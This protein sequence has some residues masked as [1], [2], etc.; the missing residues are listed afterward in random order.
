MKLISQLGLTLLLTGSAVEAFSPQ[1][2]SNVAPQQ[3]ELTSRREL[4]QKTVTSVAGVA[5]ALA[6]S[7]LAP[8]PALASGGA[9]AG[10]YTTIP[11]AK[12]RYYGRVQQSVHEF[13]LLGPEIVQAD[14]SQPM[15]QHFFDPKGLVVVAAKRKDVNGQCTKKNGDCKG[16]EV[17]D[18]IY[19]D[20]KTSMYL[21][22]NAFRLNQTKAPDNLP[23]VR[24][25]KKFFKE[26]DLVEKAATKKRK[27][28]RDSVV[29]FAAA[30]EALDAFLDLVELPPTDSNWYEQE[31][32]RAVGSSARIT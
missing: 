28:D 15:I 14:F 20:M 9:T 25:A 2:Q 29:H 6:V 11:I 5:G 8:A 12:R 32:D 27:N 26:M 22:A 18:S 21:L 19:N 13:L 16:S 3:A 7:G 4:F 1:Q 30:L 31:F 23:S 17:R 24:A 10:K